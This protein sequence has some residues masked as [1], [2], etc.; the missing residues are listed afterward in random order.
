LNIEL[1]FVASLLN[2][3]FWLDHVMTQLLEMHSGADSGFHFARHPFCDWSR[4]T[5]GTFG[6]WQ[7]GPCNRWSPFGGGGGR[8]IIEIFGAGLDA[9][10]ME[11]E[12]GKDLLEQ[13]LNV[14]IFHLQWVDSLVELPC[15]DVTVDLPWQWCSGI[16]RKFV[17][18]WQTLQNV[19]STYSGLEYSQPL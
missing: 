2:N 18:M 4:V 17:A 1:A 12:K 14:L 8:S 16:W 11:L 6:T 19:S 10:S 3:P 13:V 7:G 5:I 15:T 9:T